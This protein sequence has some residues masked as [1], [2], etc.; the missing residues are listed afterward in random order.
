RVRPGV[1]RLR[2]RPAA[3]ARVALAVLRRRPDVLRVP[4]ARRGLQAGLDERDAR[5]GPAAGLSAHARRPRQPPG[6]PPPPSALA[7]PSPRLSTHGYTPARERAD[8]GA[9]ENP[10]QV[11]RSRARGG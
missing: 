5:A 11:A 2:T 1:Q 8:A 4:R 3:H 9:Q 10:R 6:S 7:A